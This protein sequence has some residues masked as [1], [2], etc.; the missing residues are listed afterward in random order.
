MARSLITIGS[1]AARHLKAIAKDSPHSSVLIGVKGGGCN[2]LKYFIEPLQDSPESRDERMN[3][4][5]LDII[6]CGKSLLHLI[7]TEIKWNKGYMG[8]GFEFI[9]PNATSSCGCGET[10]SI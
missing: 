9:N 3:I 4:D 2:G 8:E 1:T 6:V 7:G 10:F 5:G